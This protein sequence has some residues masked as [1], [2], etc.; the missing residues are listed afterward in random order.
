MVNFNSALSKTQTA[1]EADAIFVLRLLRFARLACL[2]SCGC[3]LLA[4][5]V[6]Y[7]HGRVLTGSFYA[8]ATAILGLA[9]VLIGSKI[10]KLAA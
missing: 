7:S 3:S 9:A 4:L 8:L 10:R 6:S 2:A 5:L 1:E